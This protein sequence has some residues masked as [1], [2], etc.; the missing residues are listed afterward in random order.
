MFNPQ[1]ILHP[2]DY[3][4]CSSHAFQ[5]ASDLACQHKA[6]ILV[7]HVAETLGPENV[8]FG[9]A[10]SQLEPAAYR[11][12]LEKDLRQRVP[13]P[14]GVSIEYVLA[15]GEIA[16]EIQRLAKER[17]CDLIVL[18][19]HSRTGLSRLIMGSTAEKVIQLVSCP[20]LVTKV[21]H[22]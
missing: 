3:S 20:V 13:A 6:R 18:G 16:H 8:T 22:L 1:L 15:A 12:R 7:L 21:P 2:T 14:A 10:V 11:L 17:R 19:T 9:E 5:I 4:G